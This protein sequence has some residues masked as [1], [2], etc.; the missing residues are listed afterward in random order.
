MSPTYVPQHA[1][2]GSWYDASLVFHPKKDTWTFLTGAELE[3]ARDQWTGAHGDGGTA[4]DFTGMLKLA[5][6]VAGVY[7]LRILATTAAQGGGAGEA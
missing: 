4:F 2:D 3:A 5:A 1:V 7:G 6:L